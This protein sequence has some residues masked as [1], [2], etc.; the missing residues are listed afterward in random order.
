[1]KKDFLNI[2][3]ESGGGGST[4]VTVTA[5]PNA[6]PTSRSTTLNFS[7]TGGNLLKTVSAEQSAVPFF[8][9]LGITMGNDD[10][11]QTNAKFTFNATGFSR[12]FNNLNE[13]DNEEA[14]ISIKMSATLPNWSSITDTKWSIRGGLCILNELVGS[15]GVFMETIH[16][17]SNGQIKSN[18]VQFDIENPNLAGF[19]AY[20][21]RQTSGITY[22]EVFQFVKFAIGDPRLQALYH[23]IIE[24]DFT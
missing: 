6:Q 23:Y 20:Y 21:A 24:Y 3:P 17:E 8:P 4:Q 16:K 22:P 14:Y 1:M 12:K 10:V 19:T 13:M 18:I 15:E 11:E 7:A 9:Q 5:D 2:S